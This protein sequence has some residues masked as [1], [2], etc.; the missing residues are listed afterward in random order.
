MRCIKCRGRA[1][2]EVKRHH[3]AFC[4]VHYVEF[5]RH[6]V[7]RNIKRLR[8]FGHTNQI[9]IAVSGGKDSLALWDVLL[10]NG[11]QAVGL[12]IHLGIGDYSRRSA[13]K[14]HEFADKRGAKLLETDVEQE[15][16]LT[17]SELSKTLRRVPCSGCG[18]NKRYIFNRVALTHNFDVLAT[19]HN[20]DDEAATLLGNVLHWELDA[21]RRQSPLLESTHPTLVKKVKPLYTLTERESASYCLIRGINYV[22]EECPNA[23]G[24]HSLVYKDALNR[25]ETMSP[26]SKQ[27][28]FQG[29][30]ER[31]QPTLQ[32]SDPVVLKECKLCG[33]TT[34]GEV[35]SFCRMW[36]KARSLN[37]HA[38]TIDHQLRSNGNVAKS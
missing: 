23:L 28:F 30:L 11:Y 19:G 31:M 13:E 4:N 33:Q 35:C 25:I 20:L 17:I 34:T 5:F 1:N 9:L 8:M 15:F 32:R 2:V 27:Q 37:N 29:F 21:L 7:S 36:N 14:T 22:E 18:L 3:S 26:G 24:A 6:Q 10:E 38:T 12:H 16:G